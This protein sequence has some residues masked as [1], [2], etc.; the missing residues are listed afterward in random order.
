[1]KRKNAIWIVLAAVALLAAAALIIFNP[2]TEKTENVE[3]TMNII[4]PIHAY[5]VGDQVKS[6]CPLRPQEECSFVDAN[7]CQYFFKNVCNDFIPKGSPVE[8]TKQKI[9]GVVQYVEVRI[10]L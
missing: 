4:C 3:G 10:P 7:N 9:Q 5:Q 2:F 8:V 1:M 6:P